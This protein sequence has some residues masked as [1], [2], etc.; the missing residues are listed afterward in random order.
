VGQAQPK[1]R[2]K[3]KDE[4]EEAPAPRRSAVKEAPPL[5]ELEGVSKTFGT[6]EA[7]RDVT[8]TVRGKIIGLLGPNGA[9]KS[10]LLKSMLGLL[11][12]DGTA[13]VLG[14]DPRM[15]PFAIR[16]KV[17][18]MPESDS[19]LPGM[20]AV[21][22]CTYAG[23]LSGLPK[24]AAIQ[25]AHAA[26]YFANLEDKRYLQVEGYSTGLKQ[27][28]KLAQSLVHD[29]DLLFL[30]E[31]T[32]GLDP[33]AREEMLRMIESLP[34]R[35]GCSIIL[36]TH[37][38]PDV[39]RLCDFVIVMQAGTIVFSGTVAE[40]RGDEE[41]RFEIRVKVGTEEKFTEKLK[42]AGCV[43]EPL[44][45]GLLVKLPEGQGTELVLR[46]AIANEIQI[47]HFAPR[48]MALEEAFLRALEP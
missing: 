28:V 33:V 34:G 10:T 13:R 9:G 45:E 47:R 16:D 4:N 19:Y 18:Y 23:E 5:V 35:R 21:E 31:P 32:N 48:R 8:A 12:F 7:L 6:I 42:E 38:L 22:L 25:R 2:A 14:H 41:L 43:V 46:E 15:E 40:L 44:P 24:V 20:N 36:S 39:E 37:L 11:Q 26:L 29:P 17:G 27:R 30:D 3:K 1:K